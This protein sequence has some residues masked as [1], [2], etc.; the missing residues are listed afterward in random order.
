MASRT[1]QG[2]TE[3]AFQ[4]GEYR[5]DIHGEAVE[6]IETGEHGYRYRLVDGVFMPPYITPSRYALSRRLRTR[7]GDICYTSFPK[8]GSTWLAYILLLI[9]R[10]GEEPEGSTLRNDLHWVASSWTYPRTEAELDGLP[11]PRIFV[12]HMPLSMAVGGDPT[13]NPCKSLPTRTTQST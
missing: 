5:D 1:S 7:S 13:K 9:T 4:I 2:R 12:S 3:S 6:E 8:S 10:D 11:S